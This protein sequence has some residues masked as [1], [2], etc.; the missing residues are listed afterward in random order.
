[1]TGKIDAAEQSH[2]YQLGPET[3]QGIREQ[4]GRIFQPPKE[5]TTPQ[6]LNTSEPRAGQT[7]GV[8]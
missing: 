2:P 5:A 8:S 1:M 4:V 7:M 3:L 6:K